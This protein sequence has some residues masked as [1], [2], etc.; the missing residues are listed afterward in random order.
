MSR[1][2]VMTGAT[3][4]LGREVATRLIQQGDEVVALARDTEALPPTVRGITADL[5]QDFS[6]SLREI[7]RADA[8]VHLAQ[9]GGWHHFPSNAGNIAAVALTAT[10]RLAEFAA[11]AGARSFLF[12]SSG[13]TYGPQPEPIPETAPF[14][15]A[16]QLGFYLA[17][18][19]S[20]ESLLDYFHDYF[21]LQILR[22]FFIY[23]PGQAPAF[24]VPRL[25]S[26][27][28][29]GIPIKV[30]A[31]R[32]TRMNP[33]FISD[34]A[35]AV[36]AALK[37]EKSLTANVAGPEPTTIREIAGLIGTMLGQQPIFEDQNVPPDDYI[38]DISLMRELLGAPQVGIERGLATTIGFTE[39]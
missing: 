7:G 16:A 13:G 28:R 11:R 31:G 12:A 33:I 34:A 20:G 27:V 8:I 25:V 19:A 1:T 39:V 17:T 26:S 3:G 4:F 24:L 14:R 37:Q 38:A 36:V 30:A 15:P 10:A 35:Q 32:G 29:S 2:I 9:A 6:L 18:K 22:F 5:T 23:G 21:A